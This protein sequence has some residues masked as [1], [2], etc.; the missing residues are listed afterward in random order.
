MSRID[1]ETDLLKHYVRKYGWLKASK[2][3]KHQIGDRLKKIPLRYFTFCAADAIDVFMLLREGILTK[4]DETGR[5]EGVYFCEQDLESFGKIA[6]MIGTPEQ[7]FQG[8]FHEIVLF[9]D[10]EETKD[11]RLEDDKPYRPELRK[12]LHYKDANRRLREA[13]PFDV[14]N[15]DV[16]GVMFPSKMAP[17]GVITP[18][19]KSIDQILKWQTESSFSSSNG[20]CTQFTLFLTSHVDPDLTNQTAIQQLANRVIDNISTNKDFRSAFDKQYGHIQVKK[21]ESEDFAEFFCVALPK[22]MIHEALYDH[23][24]QVTCGPTYLYN[25]DNIWK[26]NKQYQIMHTVSVYERI[27][28]FQHRLDAPSMGQ[29]IQS[30]TQLVNNGAKWV[31]HIVEDPT[32]SLELA[33]DL[34]QIVELRDQPRDS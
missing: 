23:G 12:K 9:K 21:L 4:S 22:Y 7:G 16:C 3:Q 11:K 1:F 15:L 10:D 18:L 6:S 25:R 2:Q 29:Y 27:S 13:F 33:E 20:E 32:V 14:I 28:G 8:D 26:E 34:K 30:V 5:L 31:D 19:L 17:K 24:W